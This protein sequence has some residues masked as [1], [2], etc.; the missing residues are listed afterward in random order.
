[1]PFP[2]G[3]AD[4]IRTKLDVG[5]LPTALPEKMYAGY[6]RGHPCVACGEPIRPAQADPPCPGG[7]RNGL[8]RRPYLPLAPWLRGL[9]GSRVPAPRV[10]PGL[11]RPPF[12]F[13][14]AGQREDNAIRG[15]EHGTMARHS[16][17]RMGHDGRLDQGRRSVCRSPSLWWGADCD[18]LRDASGSEGGEVRSLRRTLL[19]GAA[20][21]HRSPQGVPR[22]SVAES[23]N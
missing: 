6:G 20:Y 2:P 13:V 22:D 4:T 23:S 12:Q 5:A 16:R 8:W 9:V 3:L 7:V 11:T 21:D 1:M 10:P 17:A 18:A 19:A 15:F 14:S